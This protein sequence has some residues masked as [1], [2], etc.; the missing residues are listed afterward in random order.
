MHIYTT[1]KSTA[2]LRLTAAL[3]RCGSKTDHVTLGST[4]IL[5]RLQYTRGRGTRSVSVAELYPLVGLCVFAK[6]REKVDLKFG[7]E[8]NFFHGARTL[9]GGVD[10]LCEELTHFASSCAI[11]CGYL[12]LLILIVIS[13]DSR[14]GAHQCLGKTCTFQVVV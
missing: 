9:L 1:T 10:C 6:K 8:P 2:A 13:R 14:L 12:L 11:A 7:S 4:G 3:T 5:P